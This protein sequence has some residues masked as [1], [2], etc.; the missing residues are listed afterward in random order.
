MDKRSCELAGTTR[1]RFA[2]LACFPVP[3]RLAGGAK[4]P[5]ACDSAR[6]EAT[7]ESFSGMATIKT[8]G[9]RE[10][11]Q[12]LCLRLHDEAGDTVLDNFGN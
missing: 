7:I 8:A 3:L 5:I 2:Y 6:C 12:R 1:F 10:R 9:S 4:H 11:G